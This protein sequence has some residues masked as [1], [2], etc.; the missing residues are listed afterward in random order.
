MVLE[1]GIGGI[2][3]EAFLSTYTVCIVIIFMA[4]MFYFYD[5]N[6]FYLS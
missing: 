6:Y 3:I 5:K 2:G 1:G 4:H